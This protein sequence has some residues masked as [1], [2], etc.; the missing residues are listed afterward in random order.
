MD[1]VLAV[2]R[3]GEV[4]VERRVDSP[5]TDVLGRAHA[6]RDDVDHVGAHRVHEDE[7]VS[8]RRHAVGLDIGVDHVERGAAIVGSNATSS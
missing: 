4:H 5:D 1:E 8:A 6:S 7:L 3:P 2:R